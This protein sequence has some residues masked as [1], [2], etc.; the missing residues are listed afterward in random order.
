M[1]SGNG[2]RRLLAG[3]RGVMNFP[4]GWDYTQKKKSAT[5]FLNH[6]SPSSNW[7]P[8]H[9]S[10][11][12][13]L[14]SRFMKNTL[15]HWS[16]KSWKTHIAWS[17]WRQSSQPPA[18]TQPARLQYACCMGR[19]ALYRLVEK[20]QT[21]TCSRQAIWQRQSKWPVFYSTLCKLFFLVALFCASF[22]TI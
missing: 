22:S 17:T 15:L 14:R 19:G 6:Y 8:S 20:T 11:G 3:L 13:I 18:R 1:G 4:T 7:L 21:A 10:L 2:K 9:I 5:N 12:L 16:I